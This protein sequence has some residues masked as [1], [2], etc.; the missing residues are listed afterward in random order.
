[1][2]IWFLHISDI[3]ALRSCIQITLCLKQTINIM[4]RTIRKQ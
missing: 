1:M 4:N 2:E 3:A